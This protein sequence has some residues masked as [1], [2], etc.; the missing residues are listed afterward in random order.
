LPFSPA[1]HH[2]CAPEGAARAAAPE[3]PGQHPDVA[4]DPWPAVPVRV[5]ELE[6]AARAEGAVADPGTLCDDVERHPVG[7]RAIHVHGET[8]P[9]HQPAT[10][11]HSPQ[12]TLVGARRAPV[13][14][15]LKHAAP[16]AT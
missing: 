8:R 1:S 4:V 12:D 6:P 3:A 7:A 10:S 15:A 16:P 11:G 5:R 2:A 14:T 13:H 9:A